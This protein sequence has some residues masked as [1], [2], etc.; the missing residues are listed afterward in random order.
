MTVW[1]TRPI[2]DSRAME[3]AL[4]A[5][6]IPTFVAPLMGIAPTPHT[7]PAMPDA[8][9]ITSRHGAAALPA[10][11]MHLPVY[12][13]GEATANA[14]RDAGATHILVGEGNALEL[15]PLIRDLQKPGDRLVHLSGAEVKIDLAPLLG[16]HRI[17]LERCVVY[18]A[19]PLP[20]PAALYDALPGITG[21][22]LYSPHSA[23]ILAYT[24][25]ASTA[26]LAQATAYCLSLDVAAAAAAVP[27]KRLVSCPVPTHQAMMELL[28]EAAITSA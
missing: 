7:L 28:S 26:K 16:A 5:K 19:Q 8:V 2:D 4:A 21:V 25:G 18:D 22:V 13:V 3:T 10:A 20:L 17:T 1:L 9:V 12:A 27:F 23:R 24:L 6:H 11:W 15:L 14:A